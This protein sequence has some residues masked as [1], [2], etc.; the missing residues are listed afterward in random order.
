MDYVSIEKVLR[1]LY[2]MQ[3]T[4]TQTQFRELFGDS[5]PYLWEKYYARHKHNLLEFYSNLDVDKKRY[6]CEYISKKLA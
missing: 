6:V 5:S 4:V 2:D 1:V 3:Y